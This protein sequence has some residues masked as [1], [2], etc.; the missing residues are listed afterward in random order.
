MNPIFLF[1]PLPVQAPD[2]FAP[3]SA[4]RHFLKMIP[5]RIEMM[6]AKMVTMSTM[7]TSFWIF[8]KPAKTTTRA[9]RDGIRAGPHDLPDPGK[10]DEAEGKVD[11]RNGDY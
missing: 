7:R 1:L 4:S 8:E 6:I 9:D 10:E 2:P 11:Y 3:F 5:T